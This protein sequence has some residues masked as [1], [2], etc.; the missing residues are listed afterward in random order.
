[1]DEDSFKIADHTPSHLFMDNAIYIIT[2]ATYRR[3]S[4][5]KR[6]DRKKQWLSAFRHAAERYG[7]EIIAW[8]VL[9]NHYHTILQAPESMT[10]NL[11]KFIGSYHKFTARIWN[12]QDG[13][14][15]RKVWWNY[16]DTCIR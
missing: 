16:W 13:R 12:D 15:G 6:D 9:N 5:I 3:I 7:W 4:Y 2:G 10:N 1:M 8:I 14:R 11:P